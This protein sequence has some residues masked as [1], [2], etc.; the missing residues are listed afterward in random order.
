MTIKY[1]YKNHL[2]LNKH[3]LEAQCL[4]LVLLTMVLHM[5]FFYHYDITA[6]QLVHRNKIISIIYSYTVFAI[7]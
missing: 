4:E 2:L 6:M 5:S 3:A 7:K 1:L